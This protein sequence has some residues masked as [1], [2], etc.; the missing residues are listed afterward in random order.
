MPACGRRVSVASYLSQVLLDPLLCL[1][2]E[3]IGSSTPFT[4]DRRMASAHW[5]VYA[6][7]AAALILSSKPMPGKHTPQAH[8]TSMTQIYKLL[9]SLS[10]CHALPSLCLP[11]CA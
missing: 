3:G 5:S 4:K 1:R 2:S 8:A 10:L 6:A 11:A 9:P 7:S